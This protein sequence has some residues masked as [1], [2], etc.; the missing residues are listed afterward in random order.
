MVGYFD[1]LFN[2]SEVH[3]L[4]NISADVSTL[5]LKNQ[6]ESLALINEVSVSR[7]GDCHG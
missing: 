4:N 6:L 2:N 5:D 1:L 3:A 7:Y